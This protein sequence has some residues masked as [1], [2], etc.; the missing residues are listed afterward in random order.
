MNPKTHL[1]DKRVNPGFRLGWHH[2]DKELI[3]W[4]RENGDVVGPLFS[5]KVVAGGVE[6]FGSCEIESCVLLRRIKF[7]DGEL[8][9]S[10]ALSRFVPDQKSVSLVAE[11]A[12][13]NRPSLI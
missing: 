5:L 9:K 13:Y 1:D 2:V 4:C 10:R 6:G 7:L 11:T 12:E 3:R 8:L